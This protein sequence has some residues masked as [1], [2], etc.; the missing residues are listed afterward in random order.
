MRKLICI[1]ILILSATASWGQLSL[2]LGYNYLKSSEWDDICHVYN[3]S[4]PW[5][6]DELSPLT[7]G[8][9]ARIG[10]LYR[11][12]T[13]R[14]LYIQPQ[15]GFRQFTSS[16]SNDGEKL[17]VRLRQYTLQTDLN[18][19]PKAFFGQVASGPIGTRWM[20]YFSPAIHIWQPY[21]EQNNIE[22]YQEGDGDTPEDYSPYTPTIFT[23]SVGLGTGYRSIM[24]A[25]KF[26]VSPKFGVRYFMKTEMEGLTDAIQP[27]DQTGLSDESKNYLI[28][29]S[30]LEIVWVFPRVK[31]G[32]GYVKPCSN[33]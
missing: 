11:W 10:W 7:H 6:R 25:K 29:E 28:F 5:Q 18:F 15:L 20:M 1:S 14:S 30:G 22:L 19:S 21:A 24:V 26:I 9:E 16:A 2:H 13:L 31:S 12:N 33:C 3:F 32:K 4:R 8:Y 17:K 27:G 23:W